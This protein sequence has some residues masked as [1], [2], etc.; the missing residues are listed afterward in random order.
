MVASEVALMKSRNFFWIIL[1]VVIVVI[2]LTQVEIDENKFQHNR[3]E[4]NFDEFEDLSKY[5][6]ESEF[7]VLHTSNGTFKLLQAFYDE[8][9]FYKFDNRGV[10][11]LTGLINKVD[12]TVR[13]FC[14][15]WFEGTDDPVI[16]QVEKYKLMWP[17]YFGFEEGQSLPY[18]IECP[19]PFAKDGKIPTAVS[20]A[21]NADDMVENYLKITFNP[22]KKGET[23][24]QFAV[25]TKSFF[26]KEDMSLQLVEWIEILLVLGA[27]KVSIATMEVHP[28]MTDMFDFYVS[29]GKIEVEMLPPPDEHIHVIQNE[30]FGFNHC[31]YRNMYK[32]KF[33]LILD[34]DEFVVP[35]LPHKDLAEMLN[36]T[37]EKKK[38][39]GY[40]HDSYTAQH[41]LFLLDNNHA[42]E[43]QPDVPKDFM[44]LQHI[45]RAANF[46][47]QGMRPK[48]FQNAE[49]TEIAHNH[50]ALECLGKMGWC[51][52]VSIEVDD[53]KLH[54]YRRT[55]DFTPEQC[56]DYSNNT[57]KDISL[58]RFKDKII[59]NVEKSLKAIEVLK[60]ADI[61]TQGILKF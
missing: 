28:N 34:V 42:N 46:C 4:F 16:V 17:L 19:N 45:Y 51:D 11:K 59:K 3:E 61:E 27:G 8:R 1:W 44:F 41:V 20:L 54:H 36:K 18:F 38:K 50:Y 21:A 32:Y 33:V 35:H 57:V 40:I 7:Q 43:I 2:I 26:F 39:F 9:R 48:S 56:D 6:I 53:G 37:V 47:E 31:L 14:Q 58:W 12:P 15:L 22:L 30:V 25:C 10:V 55:C 52:A 13:T 60:K 29:T 5:Y 24:K 23:A 49:T